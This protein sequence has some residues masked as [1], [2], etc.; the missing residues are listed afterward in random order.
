M[1]VH[2]VLTLRCF[3]RILPSSSKMQQVL[4]SLPLLLSGIDP[5]TSVMPAFFAESD[6]AE[7]DADFP[8]SMSSAYFGKLSLEYGQFHISG[9]ITSLA[10]ALAASC[11]GKFVPHISSSMP[12]LTCVQLGKVMAGTAMSVSCRI[13]KH[14]AVLS[15]SMAFCAFWIFESL[16]GETAS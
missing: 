11:I 14:S 16:S 8:S 6:I 15:T 7:T 4:Y 13:Q 12:K 10:P 5:A 9:R 1:G 2:G 3:A